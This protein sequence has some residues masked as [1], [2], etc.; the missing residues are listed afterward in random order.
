[1]NCEQYRES[2]AADPSFDGGA[3]HLSECEACQAYRREMLELD[4]LIGKALAI[5]VP[6][7]DVPEL[8]DIEA[9]NVAALPQRR[10]TSTTL[11]AM[12]AS[13]LLAA[14]IGMRMFGPG[15]E[16]SS[17]SEE[18][19][20]HLD[21][22]PY[23]MIVTDV[24][25]SDARL[26]SVVPD[27]VARMDHGAG[28]ITY[29]QSCNINGNEVPHLVIQGERGPVTLILLPDEKISAPQAIDG[30]NIKGVVLPVGNGSIALFGSPEEKFERIEKRVL[31]SVTWST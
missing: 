6:E 10:R 22:E 24:P 26:A 17:L 5:D 31:D 2:I 13:V 3:G 18:L 19:L 21:H 9:D 30:D 15:P 11:L 25:V 20:A 16:Y 29:A 1:M 27:D 7:P 14:F 8:P 12:A 28:L 23:A 4:R